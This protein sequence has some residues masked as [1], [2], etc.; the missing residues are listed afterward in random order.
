MDSEKQG[1]ELE[2]PLSLWQFIIS[3]LSNSRGQALVEFALVIPI[4]LL[5]VLGMMD[6]GIVLN[7]YLVVAEA[8]REGVRSAALGSSDTISIAVAKSAAATIDQG[9]LQ[10]SVLPAVKVRG[11]SVTVTVSN[12]VK[13]VT[14][15]ISA[16]FPANFQVQ[17]VAVMRV[18]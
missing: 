11:A 7:Q 4:F 2:K 9:N 5:L 12:P 10:V 8:A 14:P 3:P 6:M 13:I 17:G 18:E 15:L 1:L 16:F